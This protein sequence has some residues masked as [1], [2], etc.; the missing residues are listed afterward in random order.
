LLVINSAISVP[1][2][3]RLVRLVGTGWKFTITNAVTLFSALAMLIT[4]I[5]P[6]WFVELVAGGFR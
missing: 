3:L 5:P 4:L 6:T 1:Y 2:Y